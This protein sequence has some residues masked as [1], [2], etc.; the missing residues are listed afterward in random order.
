MTLLWGAPFSSGAPVFSLSLLTLSLVH[1]LSVLVTRMWEGPGCYR[2]PRT[3]GLSEHS[4]ELL[5]V[6]ILTRPGAWEKDPAQGLRP[7]VRGH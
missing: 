1:P 3:V 4:Q 6:E 7:D 2:E 5:A